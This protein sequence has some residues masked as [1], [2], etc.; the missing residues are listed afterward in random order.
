[1]Y[2]SKLLPPIPRAQF[3]RRLLAH[4]AVAILLVLLSL[5]LG[6]AGYEHFERLP[7]RDAFLNSA[8]L[9]GGMGPVD[10][11]QTDGGKLFAG[12]YALYAGLVFLVT[13]SVVLAP[14]VHRALHKFHWSD[15]Q[16]N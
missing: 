10:G 8:M 3:I 7:W 13:V 12:L 11:P 1:V 16:Q 6:M 4:F 14:V 2:E 15:D 5:L 9:L